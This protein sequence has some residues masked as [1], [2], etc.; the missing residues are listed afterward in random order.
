[1]G[2]LAPSGNVAPHLDREGT[3]RYWRREIR[4]RRSAL[5]NPLSAQEVA[6]NLNRMRVEGD[7]CTDYSRMN[8]DEEEED[9]KPA[10]PGF[11]L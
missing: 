2:I 9:V 1:M 5:L 7:T 11:M 6:A 10:G 3:I 8:L 4:P